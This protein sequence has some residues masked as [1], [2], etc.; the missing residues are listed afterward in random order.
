MNPSPLPATPT[1]APP[2]LCHARGCDTEIE[3][4]L[5]MCPA[6]WAQVPPVLRESIKSTYRPGQELD[7]QPSEQYLAFAAAAIA[8]VAH[9]EERQRQRG[10]RAPS[11][12]VQLALF[13]VAPRR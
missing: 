11:K 9:K 8:E 7:K 3:P 4:R 13:D 5:F 1:E 10:R 2:H 6:H 12:P